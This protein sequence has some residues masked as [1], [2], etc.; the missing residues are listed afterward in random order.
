M[1]GISTVKVSDLSE[2]FNQL[3]SLKNEIKQLKDREDELKAF[4]ISQTAEMLNL[5]YNSVRKL[6]IHKK[7]FAKYLEGNSGKTII[8]LWSIKAYLQSKENSNQ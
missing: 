2:I 4:T 1:D 5:H 6:I 8:P 7:L 3:T